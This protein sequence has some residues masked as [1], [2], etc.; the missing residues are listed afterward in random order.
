[1]LKTV[2]VEECSLSVTNEHFKSFVGMRLVK[3][4]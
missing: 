1:M 3:D 4:F 2:S